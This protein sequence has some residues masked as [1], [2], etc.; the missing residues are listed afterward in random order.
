MYT[1][2]DGYSDDDGDD[3]TQ[4][5][6]RSRSASIFANN[7]RRASKVNAYRRK[8]RVNFAQKKLSVDYDKE[9]QISNNSKRSESPELELKENI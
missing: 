2:Q 5:R 1:P 4:R 6:R 3:Y 9:D 7:I 8:S